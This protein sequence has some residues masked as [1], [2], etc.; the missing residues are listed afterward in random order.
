MNTNP[1]NPLRSGPVS[2]IHL[3]GKL[4]LF[5]QTTMHTSSRHVLLISGREDD[6]T[7]PQVTFF[8]PI[9]AREQTVH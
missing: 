5:T 1:L 8:T 2:F 3:C 6:G 7:S 9:L 4:T